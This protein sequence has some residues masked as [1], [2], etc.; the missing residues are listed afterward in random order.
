MV[1]A[2]ALLALGSFGCAGDPPSERAGSFPTVPSSK[3]A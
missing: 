1:I 3:V 2:G